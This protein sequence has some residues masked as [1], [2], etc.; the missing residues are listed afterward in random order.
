M[1]HQSE[2]A[3]Q[4]SIDELAGKCTIVIVAHRLATVR[5]ADH[6]IVLEDGRV[7]EQGSPEA[8]LKRGGALAGL[9]LDVAASGVTPEQAN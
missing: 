7:V 3:I 6:V 1:D 8:L 5:R 9:Y 2:I 4:Q